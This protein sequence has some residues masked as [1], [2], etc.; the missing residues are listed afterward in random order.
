MIFILLKEMKIKVIEI[1]DFDEDFV[2]VIVV[3]SLPRLFFVKVVVV[4]ISVNV[5][6]V[7]KVVLSKVI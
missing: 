1:V 7:G 5:V 3:V 4:V 2:D 6:Q